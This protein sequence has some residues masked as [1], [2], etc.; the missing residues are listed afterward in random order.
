MTIS[1]IH[2]IVD[3][4]LEKTVET[5]TSI[6]DELIHRYISAY[7]AK[8]AGLPVDKDE[9]RV[10]L[11]MFGSYPASGLTSV[12]DEIADKY[13]RTTTK[14]L[15]RLYMEWSYRYGSK[16]RDI[17]DMEKPDPGDLEPGTDE[18]VQMMNSHIDNQS[19][20]NVNDALLAL[21]VSNT[22]CNRYEFDDIDDNIFNSAPYKQF[23]KINEEVE[24]FINTKHDGYL[25][26]NWD[27]LAS[28]LDSLKKV[29]HEDIIEE[30]AKEQVIQDLEDAEHDSIKKFLEDWNNKT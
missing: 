2:E 21:G 29:V 14:E 24:S 12:I 28:T 25:V 7:Y 15:L 10:V 9:R 19:S 22:I 20:L 16:G 26:L 6:R 3:Y 23:V 13:N 17:D 18:I 27:I 5:D 8:G 4:L 1:D 11:N 30:R